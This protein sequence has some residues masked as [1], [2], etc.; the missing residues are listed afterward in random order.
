MPLLPKSIIEV[1]S[2][3]QAIIFDQPMITHHFPFEQI[4]EAYELQN[5]LDE[6][7]VKIVIDMPN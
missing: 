3:F 2:A 5:T 4:Q 1:D 6:G 7:A